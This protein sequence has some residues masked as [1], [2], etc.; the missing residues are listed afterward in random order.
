M[1]GIGTKVSV[2]RGGG[3]VGEIVRGGVGARIG[4]GVETESLLTGE[5]IDNFLVG[6]EA[7]SLLGEAA[8]ALL[9]DEAE[10]LRPGEEIELGT[11]TE[12]LLENAE[13]YSRLSDSISSREGGLPNVSRKFSQ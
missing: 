6:E 13:P 12:D 7:D 8:D 4:E 10:S 11:E 9:G 2:S 5:V 3:T 1:D